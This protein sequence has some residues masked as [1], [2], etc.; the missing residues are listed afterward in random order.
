MHDR[1]QLL[2]AVGASIGEPEPGETRSTPEL[3]H[4]AAVLASD[5]HRAPEAGFP[6]APGTRCQELALQPEQLRLEPPLVRRLDRGECLCDDTLRFGQL[7]KR[8]VSLREA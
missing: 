6:M 4:Q 3:E 1:A 5:I 7:T 8:P 2:H